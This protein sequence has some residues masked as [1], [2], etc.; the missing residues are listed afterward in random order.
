MIKSISPRQL[1]VMLLIPPGEVITFVSGLRQIT[2]WWFSAG[3]LI[4]F[5]QKKYIYIVEL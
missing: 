2:G 4:S 3:I 1:T 5:T